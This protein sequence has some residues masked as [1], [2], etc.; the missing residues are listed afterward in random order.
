MTPAHK[1]HLQRLRQLIKIYDLFRGQKSVNLLM[2]G[3][4]IILLPYLQRIFRQVDLN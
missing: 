4:N 3:L 2:S 1:A